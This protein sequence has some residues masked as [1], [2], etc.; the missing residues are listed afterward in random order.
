MATVDV[1]F[2]NNSGIQ[3]ASFECQALEA[4]HELNRRQGCPRCMEHQLRLGGVAFGQR[5]AAD[6][7]RPVRHHSDRVR[8]NH[9]AARRI[10]VP[11]MIL[12]Q[13]MS[14]RDY[15]DGTAKR[16]NYSNIQKKS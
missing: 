12:G 13:G 8:T 2:A 9:Y 16:C 5:L 11:S 4:H 15:D 3:L 6:G 1:T 14:W 7:G 10:P